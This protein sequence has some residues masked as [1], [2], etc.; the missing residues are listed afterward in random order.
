MSK[1]NAQ[2]FR[3]P[4]VDPRTGILTREWSLYFSQL[5]E[6]VGGSDGQSTNELIVDLHDDAGIEEI[7]FD[8]YRLRDELNTTPAPQGAFFTPEADP[9]ARIEALEALVMR[10]ASEID[11][12]K[13]GTL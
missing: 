5:F 13:Q 8:V 1:L 10:L 4:L 2:P 3:V 6:R 7:K 12:L 9:H 11:A